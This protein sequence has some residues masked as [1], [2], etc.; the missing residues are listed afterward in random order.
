METSHF[1]SQLL[2]GE[3]ILWQGQPNKEAFDRSERHL[4]NWVVG[5]CVVWAI[6]YWIHVVSKH[7][8]VYACSSRGLPVVALFFGLSLLTKIVSIRAPSRAGNYWYAV[9]NQRIFAEMP[10][11]GSQAT[12]VVPLHDVKRVSFKQVPNQPG[13]VTIRTKTHRERLVYFRDIQE[14]T[15]ACALLTELTSRPASV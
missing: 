10:D 8:F 1:D 2:L 7:G 5:F 13:T 15:G 4:V 14:A 11:E 9:T 3:R 6:A 12:I